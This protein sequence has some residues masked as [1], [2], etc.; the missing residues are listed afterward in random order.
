MVKTSVLRVDRQLV[1]AA[2]STTSYSS[3]ENSKSR[4]TVVE[5]PIPV[6]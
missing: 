3:L 2:R 1:D 6:E 5:N 4:K